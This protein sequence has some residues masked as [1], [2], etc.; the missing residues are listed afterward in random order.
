MTHELRIGRNIVSSLRETVCNWFFVQCR[1]AP[2]C[3][4]STIRKGFEIL[5]CVPW[6]CSFSLELEKERK[7]FLRAPRAPVPLKATPYMLIR[8]V[9]VFWYGDSSSANRGNIS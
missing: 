4:V 2:L 7:Y 9:L 5:H 1:L 6:Y 8:V 3:A